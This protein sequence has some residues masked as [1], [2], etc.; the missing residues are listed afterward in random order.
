MHQLGLVLKPKTPQSSWDIECT[1][2]IS[3]FTFQLSNCY[4]NLLQLIVSIGFGVSHIN[5]KFLDEA[6]KIG[7][8]A[9]KG[10]CHIAFEVGWYAN[11]LGKSP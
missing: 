1:H 6:L 4:I 2:F 11:L 3:P 7:M 10:R 5:A 9:D 8:T